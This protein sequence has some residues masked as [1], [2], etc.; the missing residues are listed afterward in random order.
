MIVIY[1]ECNNKSNCAE[2]N[3]ACY[4]HMYV[5]TNIQQNNVSPC[6]YGCYVEPK[7]IQYAVGHLKTKWFK[8]QKAFSTNGLVSFP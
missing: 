3:W 7:E 1:V 5:H 6:D 4:L 2:S 8:K